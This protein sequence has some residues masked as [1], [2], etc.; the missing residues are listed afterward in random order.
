[1]PLSA[2]AGATWTAFN[3]WELEQREMMAFPPY[4]RLIRIVYRGKEGRK[5]LDALEGL[6]ES[7]R[8]AGLPDV[9]GP[10]ECPL[11]VISGNFR[12]HTLLRCTDDFSGVHRIAA[13]IIEGTEVPRGVYRE[14]DIDPVQLL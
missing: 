5:V 14:I 8:R 7:F 2:E 6:T 10:A 11:G 9:M 1:M 12:Y 4:S 13:Q 3:S